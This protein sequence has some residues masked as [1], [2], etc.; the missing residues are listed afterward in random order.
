M[1]ER[2]SVYGVFVGKPG[3]MRPLERPSRRWEDNIKMDLQKVEF[4]G[5]D[6]IEVTQDRHTWRAFVHAVMNLRIP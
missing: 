3:G 2:R 1:G 4:G 5:I 6:R